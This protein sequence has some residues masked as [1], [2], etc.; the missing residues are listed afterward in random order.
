MTPSPVQG[1]EINSVQEDSY[2]SLEKQRALEV[3]AKY[4]GPRI[5]EK[6]QETE[7]NIC[8]WAEKEFYVPETESPIRLLPHQKTLLNYFFHN[9]DHRFTTFVFSTVKKSGKTA[10]ASLVG[11]YIA[12]NWGSHNEVYCM[13]NDLEQARGRIYQKIINSIELTPGWDG[14]RYLPNKWRIVEKDATYLPNGSTIRAVSNDHKGEAGSNPTATLWS[15]LWGFTS[16]SSRRLYEELTPV[17]TRERSI[18]WVETYAGYEDESEL[19]IKLYEQG[20]SG[21][22]LTREEID[23]PEDGNPVPIWFNEQANLIMYWDDGPTARRMPWQTP[24]YYAEQAVTI[25]RQAT[26]DR[27]HNNYWTNSKEAFI[28]IEWWDACSDSGIVFPKNW[29]MVLALDAGVSSDSCSLVGVSR[30]PDIQNRPRDVVLRLAQVWYPPR[31][32]KINFGQTI[33]PA[34]L[35][36][37]ANYNVVQLAFDEYQLHKFIEDLIIEAVVWCRKFSQ[38]RDRAVADK[39]LY[40]MILHKQIHHN[41]DQVVREHIKNAAAKIDPADE[42]KL[43]LIKKTEDKKIDAAVA[44]SMAVEECLR[45]NL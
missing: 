30:H 15:E 29:P 23:W 14:K 41:N 26:F 43:R 19:L 20:K 28:P 6:R 11:R 21:R 7:L 37:C 18:R 42:S 27:L 40:D 3:L 34:T 36:T 16:E 2:T 9:K 10:I 45:L 25:T 32:G 22:Q 8:N 38:Q 17:P 39:Q 5:S 33:W 35:F 13:A 44:L 24:E 31:G 4:L 1:A 12:Q